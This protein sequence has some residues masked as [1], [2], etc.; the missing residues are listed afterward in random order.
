MHETTSGMVLER[1]N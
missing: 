1:Y